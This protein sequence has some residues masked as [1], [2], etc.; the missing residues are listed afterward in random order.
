M[1]YLTKLFVAVRESN[2][3]QTMNEY[4]LIITALAVTGMTAYRTLGGHG[5]MEFTTITAAF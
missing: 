5:T 3:G 4:V 1:N 2:K